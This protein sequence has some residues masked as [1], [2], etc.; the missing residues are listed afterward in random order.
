MSAVAKRGYGGKS[1]EQRRA[2]RRGAFLQAGRDLWCENGWPAVTMRGVCARAGLADRY[3]YQSFPDRD[4]LLVAVAEEVRNEVLT[5]IIAAL[6]E[7]ADEP[8]ECQLRSALTA[9]VGLVAEDPGS[10]QIFFGEHGGSDVLQALRRDTTEAVV[11]L[12]T[13]VGTPVVAVGVEPVEFRVVLLVGIG[14]FVETMTAW[15]AG[16]LEATPDELVQILMDVS[17]RM[18]AGLLELGGPARGS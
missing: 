16:S 5:T 17:Q 7:H 9:V 10:M 12:F 3:F 18:A 4:A 11:D 1:A 14:G 13:T 6:A 15:R 2:E 8:L